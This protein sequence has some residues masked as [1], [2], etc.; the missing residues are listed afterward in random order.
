MTGPTNSVHQT[1]AKARHIKLMFH[2]VD[3]TLTDIYQVCRR[4]PTFHV[5]VAVNRGETGLRAKFHVSVDICLLCWGKWIHSYI[6]RGRTSS[7][8][9]TVCRS[10]LENI[11][12]IPW[13]MFVEMQLF[14]LNT[15]CYLNPN[16]NINIVIFSWL[17]NWIDCIW[18][19]LE[20][21][22]NLIQ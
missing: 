18:H 10:G 5:L 11:G 6:L 2:C 17:D 1:R 21:K 16:F 22:M 8:G 15:F 9:Q 12:L 20:V 19:R 3:N 13:R 14:E 4:I 7:E